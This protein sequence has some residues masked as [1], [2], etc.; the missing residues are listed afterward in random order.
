[1]CNIFRSDYITIT[2]CTPYDIGGHSIDRLYLAKL[3]YE[4]DGRR[5]KGMMRYMT[6]FYFHLKWIFMSPRER[7]GYLWTK[8]KKLGNLGNDMQNT[9]PVCRGF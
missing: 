1:M 6:S 8:A 3:P 4:K 2:L 7:Y 5:M 9:I